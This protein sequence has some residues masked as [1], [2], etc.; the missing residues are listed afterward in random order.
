MDLSSE[1][2]CKAPSRFDIGRL[3]KTLGGVAMRCYSHLSDDEREQI[4]LAKALGH[5]IGAIAQAIGRLKY[6]IKA[7]LDAMPRRSPIILVNSEGR[8]W[9]SDGFRA[10]FFKARDAAGI[11]GLTFHDLRGTAVT[12][13][14]L[15]GYNEAR[16]AS[17]T[18][19]SLSDVSSILG[20]HYL[21]R[22]PELACDAI[23]KLEMRYA[24]QPG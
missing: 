22:D 17:I 3:I 19:H 14:A 20:A 2:K 4:G 24:K 7:M 12:R 15:G 6:R 13:L 16:I 11:S 5:S 10:S 23:H 21:H 8:P 1:T 18:G 9:T